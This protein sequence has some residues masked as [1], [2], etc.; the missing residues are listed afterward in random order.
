M[1]LHAHFE[2]HEGMMNNIINNSDLVYTID[3]DQSAKVRKEL[4]H[5]DNNDNEKQIKKKEAR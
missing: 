1:I 2:K 3:E 4:E 5:K